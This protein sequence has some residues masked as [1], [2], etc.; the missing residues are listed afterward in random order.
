MNFRHGQ[1]R[2]PEHN[3]WCAI[4]QRCNNPKYPRYA[5]YGGRGITV[6]PRWNVF[7]NF[8]A[9]MGQR[10]SPKHSIERRDNNGPYAPENCVWATNRQQ[11]NNRGG[12]KANVL[13]TYAGE[14]LN[15]T[16][17][18]ART[19]LSGNQIRNRIRKGWT[20][21]KILTTPIDVTRRAH[22]AGGWAHRH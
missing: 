22:R 10:P 3:A 18:A 12:R 4:H 16:Q 1:S 19:G 8:L 15:V 14:T 9:D 11:A 7:E 13:L 6:D 5:R 2:T 21:E 20:A 17:W